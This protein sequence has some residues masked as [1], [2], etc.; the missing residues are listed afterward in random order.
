MGLLL[1]LLG[2]DDD[3]GL[4]GARSRA[5]SFL[6]AHPRGTTMV[7]VGVDA[8][9]FDAV[10]GPRWDTTDLA[11]FFRICGGAPTVSFDAELSVGPGAF[12]HPYLTQH[13]EGDVSPCV[14]D[15]LA[16]FPV[17]GPTGRGE[18]VVFVVRWR[19]D[20][21]GDGTTVHEQ[22]GQAL[23]RGALALAPPYYRYGAGIAWRFFEVDSAGPHFRYEPGPVYAGAL[24]APEEWART[25]TC[26]AAERD[27]VRTT[28]VF[29]NGELDEVYTE[30][31]TSCIEENARTRAASFHERT[32]GGEPILHLDHAAV[33]L[34]V[35]VRPW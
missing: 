12:P 28:L 16:T 11:E 6:A 23:P 2:C 8:P 31:E 20:E 33:V 35:P 22:A 21:E 5:G 27:L 7:R 34:D 25:L 24:L 15:R 10:V 17:D 32:V 3:A 18:N 29:D 4:D 14:W 19:P 13:A 26:N 1:I 9:D 30:P